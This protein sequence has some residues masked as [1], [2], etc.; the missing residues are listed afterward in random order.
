M[1]RLVSLLCALIL[2]VTFCIGASAANTVIPVATLNKILDDFRAAIKNGDSYVSLADYD[3]YNDSSGATYGELFDYFIRV[4]S[5]V[6]C[7]EFGRYSETFVVSDFDIDASGRFKGVKLKYPEKYTKPDGSCDMELI[8]AD[9][10]VVKERYRLAKEIA[11][12]RM[13]DTDKAL[14]LYDFVMSCACYSDPEETDDEGNDKYSDSSYMVVGLLRDGYGVCA[15]YAKLYALLL[16]DCGIPAVTVYCERINHEWVM[17]NVDGEWYHADPTWDDDIGSGGIT[18]FFDGS[19]DSWDIGSVTHK[20]F[21]KSDEEFKDLDHPDW[22]LSY[23][24]NPDYLDT[25]PRS[26]PSGKFK[27]EFFDS[28][29]NDYIT[30]SPMSYINGNWYFPD[31]PTRSVVRISSD[32]TA[33]SF[34]CP[35]DNDYFRY[36]FGYGSNLYVS[37]LY[38]IYRFDTIDESFDKIMEIPE[39]KRDTDDYSEMNVIFDEMTLITV[40]Y[41]SSDVDETQ[42]TSSEEKFDMKEL[43]TKEAIS[44]AAAQDISASS[45]DRET[46]DSGDIITEQNDTSRAIPA[47]SDNTL[48]EKAKAIKGNAIFYLTLAAVVVI[49]CILSIVIAAVASKRR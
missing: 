19:E 49:V 41:A 21:L 45:I 42:F 13:S 18:A 37:S 36:S 46:Q 12:S 39:D 10:A 20:Y 38:G 48:S 3:L 28:D 47:K 4:C 30:M 40:S 22:A 15:A 26:G 11:G 8:N 1:K 14:A 35:D 17:L 32:G 16:N 44:S 2:A 27:G 43:E 5:D 25:P 6:G 7:F 23:T 31:V 33:A 9:R 24:V 34:T 29:N